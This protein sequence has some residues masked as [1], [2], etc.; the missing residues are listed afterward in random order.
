[1]L[2]SGIWKNLFIYNLQLGLC[3]HRVFHNLSG[4]VKMH[5]R[6]SFKRLELDIAY[7]FATSETYWSLLF[8]K[9]QKAI[10]N[11]NRIARD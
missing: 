3:S 8:L 4:I 10:F 11:R 2:K 9:I 7:E 6:F 5:N 1:M